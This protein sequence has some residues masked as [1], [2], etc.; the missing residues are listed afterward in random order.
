MINC[1]LFGGNSYNSIIMS[2]HVI[3][4]AA[5]WG[6]PAA[7]PAEKAI[8][9]RSWL[10]AGFA[11]SVCTSPYI[12]HMTHQFDQ[13]GESH[14]RQIKGNSCSRLSTCWS[15]RGRMICWSSWKMPEYETEIM[16]S[17]RNLYKGKSWNHEV[18]AAA[19]SF[20]YSRLWFKRRW[21][22][23]FDRLNMFVYTSESRASNLLFCTLVHDPV[24]ALPGL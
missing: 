23:N 10:M 2:S 11:F 20:L 22:C 13:V 16:K 6:T 1:S 7:P 17:L 19:G 15:V 14:T 18:I 8:A 9:G 3:I 24:V 12:A 4:S 5:V 21:G